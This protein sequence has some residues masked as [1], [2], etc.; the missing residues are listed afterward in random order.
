MK[1]EE[2]N[3]F[4]SKEQIASFKL[5]TM[6]NIFLYFLTFAL[7]FNLQAQSNWSVNPFDYQYTMTVTAA[8]LIDC[9]NNI[10]PDDSV[11]AFV[12]TTC[13]GVVDFGTDINGSNIA[14]LIVYSNQSLGEIIT[15]KIYDASSGLII[16]ILDSSI[17]EENK[18]IGSGA[19]P[20]VM[21][22][23]SPPTS[24]TLNNININDGS[25]SGDTI[26]LLEVADLDGDLYSYTFINSSSNNN[27]QFTINGN[28][29]VLNQ[30][31]DFANQ[32]SYQIAI[33]AASSATCL[34]Q[35]SFL[36]EVINTNLPP[37]DISFENEDNSIFENLAIGSLVSVLVSTDS[38]IV[39]QHTYTF[40]AGG[41]DNSFFTINNNE[42]LSA[43]VFNY[44]DRNEYTIMVRTTD[45][46]GNFYIKELVVLVDDV[47]ELSDIKGNNVI[48]P[49]GDGY[50]DFFEVPNITLFE[51]F[52]FIVFNENG[53]LIYRRSPSAGYNNLWDGKTT[54]GNELPSG[55][56]YYILKDINNPDFKFTG[57]LTLIR[58]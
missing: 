9:Q 19:N 16:N 20:F 49:N 33:E 18:S 51:N 2:P 58:N 26:A 23:N 12:G 48:T 22:N 34:I 41:P 6:K 15:Y 38:S 1:R 4:I 27:S 42:L 45:Q 36:L 17:F 46:A 35:D 47:L 37:T 13:R 50:N 32:M 11:A 44:E 57:E 52:E 7:G 3:C 21:S 43:Y 10:A 39:D 29:I 56:Y 28:A 55:A 5:I 53:N 54:N 31:V 24:L 40:E 14:Y 25:Q 8:A 30:D